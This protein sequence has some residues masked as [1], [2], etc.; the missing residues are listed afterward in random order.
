MMTDD[1]LTLITEGTY[2]PSLRRSMERLEERLHRGDRVVEMD[3]RELLHLFSRM[4]A[5]E[6][7]RQ[8]AYEML[9]SAFSGYRNYFNAHYQPPPLVREPEKKIDKPSI[10]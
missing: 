2:D 9:N 4:V 6:R 10:P 1:Q 3:I 7:D 8:R 5:T